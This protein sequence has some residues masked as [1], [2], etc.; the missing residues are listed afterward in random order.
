MQKLKHLII[1]CGSAGMS[2]LK[3]IRSLNASHDV[4]MVTMETC[5]PYSPMSLPYVLSG[6]RKIDDIYTVD[7][8]YFE[9]MRVKR[10]VGK[11]VEGI[12][13]KNQRVITPKGK[14]RR[15]THC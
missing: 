14:A 2:A 5:P 15:T 8:K 13:T 12:D 11:R 9:A 10:V 7:A 1:G 3:Q 4:T 6:R